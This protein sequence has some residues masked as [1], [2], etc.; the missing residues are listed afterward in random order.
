MPLC[1]LHFLSQE[2]GSPTNKGNATV[3]LLIGIQK[4]NSIII[5]SYGICRVSRCSTRPTRLKTDNYFP[6]NLL[7]IYWKY[8]VH[9]AR[10]ISDTHIPS[11]ILL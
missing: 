9:T 7:R 1:L 2:T 5:C 10:L 4:F 6:A 8:I 11:D 3:P